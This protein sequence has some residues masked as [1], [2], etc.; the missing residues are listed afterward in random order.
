MRTRP[1]PAEG[2]M[3]LS[4]ARYELR[5]VVWRVRDTDLGDINLLGQRMSDIYVSG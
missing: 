4:P 2:D 3:S 1:P 5:C